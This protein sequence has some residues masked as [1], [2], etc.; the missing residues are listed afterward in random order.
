MKYQLNIENTIDRKGNVEKMDNVNSAVE[1]FE[2]GYA[3]SQAILT[4]FCKLYDLDEK[5]ALKLSAGFAGGMRTANICGAITGAYMILG[6]E[7]SKPDCSK[8][9]ADVYNAIAEF[10][11]RFNEIHGSIIC[12]DI[13]GYNLNK[14]DEFNIIK[15]KNLFL[16]ICP[17]AIKTSGEILEEMLR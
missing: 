15:E 10:N 4:T 9:R 14:P 16:T 5:I 6:L 2:N 12:S 1:K 13:L 11:N 3:C 7:F 17:G 8:N